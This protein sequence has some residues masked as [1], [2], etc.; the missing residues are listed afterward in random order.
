VTPALRSSPLARSAFAAALLVLQ[1]C[2]VTPAGPSVLLLPGA[3]KSQ[4]QFQADQA[5]CQQQAQ[6]QVAPSV[7]AVNNQAAATAVVGTAIGAAIGALMGYGGYGGYGQ[8]ANQ[9]AAWGAGAGLMYG[10]AMGGGSSQASNP[11][12][13]QRYDNAF[14][15]CMVLLGH[16]L[17]GVAGYRRAA[18]AVPPP[19]PSYPPPNTRPPSVPPP[20]TPAPLGA[21]APA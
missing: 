2:A 1:G 4:A 21:V 5:G 7:D 9:A 15:Q 12:L 14:A 18:P 20:N 13:Q 17:P 8:Y 10:G 16:Q 19:P 6:T 11:G 3:Q